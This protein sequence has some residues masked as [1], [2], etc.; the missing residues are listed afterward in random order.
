MAKLSRAQFHALE[1]VRKRDWPAGEPRRGWFA[2]P[3]LN[4]LFRLNLV[5]ERFPDILHLTEAGRAALRER[6]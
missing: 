4:V 6:E 3:T 2:K 1:M 5:E